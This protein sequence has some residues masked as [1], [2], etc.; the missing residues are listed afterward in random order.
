MPVGGGVTGKEEEADHAAAVVP[1]LRFPDLA[2]QESMTH[3]YL[4]ELVLYPGEP[5]EAGKA[6]PFSLADFVSDVDGD[7]LLCPM[8]WTPMPVPHKGD[9]GGTAYFGRLAC[10]ACP[11]RGDCPVEIKATLPKLTYRHKEVRLA[12]HRAIQ[13][14]REY[15]ERYRLR[16]RDRGYQLPA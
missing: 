15:A 9:G 11:R 12:L 13:L 8:G 5:V 3:E 1:I 16:W 7:I 4:L 2:R 6:G 14:T 10:L